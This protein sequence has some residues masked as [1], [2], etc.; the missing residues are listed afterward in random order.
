ML[1]DWTKSTISCNST[2]WERNACF[3]RATVISSSHDRLRDPDM[4][5]EV[6]KG[7]NGG[8][9]WKTTSFINESISEYDSPTSAT[10]DNPVS[11]ATGDDL[12]PR[13]LNIDVEGD[14][15]C[16][17]IS[18]LRSNRC[19]SM[20]RCSTDVFS[21]CHRDN[22]N[23][24][25]RPLGGD[26]TRAICGNSS[27]WASSSSF[28]CELRPSP[29]KLSSPGDFNRCWLN[30]WYSD[31]GTGDLWVV[32]CCLLSSSLWIKWHRVP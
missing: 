16:V 9:G 29:S 23:S 10:D 22:R 25:W 31:V 24:A 15:Q 1:H 27:R 7:G 11:N 8:N 26:M 21:C 17:H 4:R 32:E 20:R 18:A 19:P 12:D 13:R 28:V 5:V 14:E 2:S 30:C 3:T 6:A